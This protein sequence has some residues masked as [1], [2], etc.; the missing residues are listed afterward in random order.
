ML[1]ALLLIGLFVAFSCSRRSVSVGE[2]MTKSYSLKVN[3]KAAV[4]NAV[5]TLK[6]VND[7]RCPVNVN[8]VRAGEAIAVLNVVINNNSERNINLCTG[9]DCNARALSET[10]TL[11]SD[12]E[13]YLFRLDSITPYPGKGSQ[14]EKK[15]Y[16]SVTMPK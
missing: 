4:A 2:E 8:C 3:E 13:K 7:S 15:V 16:F 6:Q 5:I 9:A 11:S 14:E 12:G 1:R 10:Y